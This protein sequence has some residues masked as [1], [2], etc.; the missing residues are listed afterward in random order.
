MNF[1]HIS[2]VFIIIFEFLD[3]SSGGL[4]SVYVLVLINISVILEEGCV[5]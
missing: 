1:L 5:Y 3:G 2:H 4:N